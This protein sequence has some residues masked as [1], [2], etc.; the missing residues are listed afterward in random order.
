MAFVCTC[1]GEYFQYKFFN[2]D[3]EHTVISPVG[4]DDWKNVDYFAQTGISPS[5][6]GELEY[7]FNLIETYRKIEHEQIFWSGQEVSAFID[8][9][10]RRRIMDVILGCTRVLIERVQPK[11]FFRCADAGMPPKA[12]EK[13]YLISN[14]LT[15]IGYDVRIADPYMGKQ[16]WYVRRREQSEVASDTR[17]G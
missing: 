9:D 1:K 3:N 7:Y 12:L 13:H 16:V 15:E 4:F 14:V 8:K 5:G 11:V 10:D 6:G 17:S 2:F